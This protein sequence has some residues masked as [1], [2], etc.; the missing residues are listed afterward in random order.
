MSIEKRLQALEK[1]RGSSRYVFIDKS[2]NEAEEEALARYV[3][4]HGEKPQGA[5][6][7]MGPLDWE[8]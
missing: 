8:I 3:A 1:S 5:V 7:F 2:P 4:E 6:I